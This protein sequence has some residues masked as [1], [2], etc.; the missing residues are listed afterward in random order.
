MKKLRMSL[1]PAELIGLVVVGFIVCLCFR[2]ILQ[3]SAATEAASESRGA[4]LWTDPR[5]LFI[6]AV[7]IAILAYGYGRLTN[8]LTN[9]EELL[10]VFVPRVESVDG[11]VTKIEVLC[12][13][14]RMRHSA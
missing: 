9:L 10:K 8:R 11:R 5:F 3:A 13:E 2:P 12:P 1:T 14:C 4:A 6:V 7:Q